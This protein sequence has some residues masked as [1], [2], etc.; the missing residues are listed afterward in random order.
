MCS[1]EQLERL[2]LLALD[3]QLEP[4]G[5]QLVSLR[6]RRRFGGDCGGCRES[7][8]KRS[9][10]EC[11]SHRLLLQVKT[12]ELNVVM[13]SSIQAT[14]GAP[15]ASTSRSAENT[16]PLPFATPVRVPKV[17][18]Q[19]APLKRATERTSLELLSSW[20]HSKTGFPAGSIAT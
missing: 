14:V 15:D 16:L 13:S 9:D 11:Q 8:E 7:Q 18:S 4:L 5:N 20:S 3:P 12:E 2:D 6:G 10:D 19:P 17:V 1:Q